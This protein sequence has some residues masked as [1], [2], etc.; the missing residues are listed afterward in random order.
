MAISA[1]HSFVVLLGEGI[2]RSMCSMR[3][4]CAS[5]SHL[6]C[7][8]NPVEVVIAETARVAVSLG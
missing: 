3:S 6:L 8:S 1:G 5:V 7:N 4:K 2:Y